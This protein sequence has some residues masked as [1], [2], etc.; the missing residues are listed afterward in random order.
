MRIDYQIL[1]RPLCRCDGYTELTAEELRVFVALIENGGRLDSL[2]LLATSA[3]VSISRC[4]SALTMLDAIGI[5]KEENTSEIGRGNGDTIVKDESNS[6]N[7][8]DTDEHKTFSVTDEF[9]YRLRHGEI[10]SVSSVEVARSIRDS[11]LAEMYSECERL[12]GRTLNTEETKILEGL[13]TQ[14]GLSPEY[15]L[16]YASYLSTKHKVNPQML[17]TSAIKMFERGYDTVE[18]L[19]GYI[20]RAEKENGDV[21]ELKRML[22]INN[23]TLSDAE[24]KYV[25]R[26]YGDFGF[27]SEIISEAYGISAIG[28]SKLSFPYMDKILE[29]WH[30]AGCVSLEDCRK[31]VEREREEAKATAAEK[32]KRAKPK[33]EPKKPRYGSFDV[34]E[35]FRAALN[36]SF[37][38]DGTDVHK[39]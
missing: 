29:K 31:L 2:D 27:S 26:W 11:G 4:R 7:E 34:D 33:A 32:K 5:I 15:I 19:E 3:G 9:E 18:A 25:N 22:G 37:G 28:T 36:R 35:A 24:L 23:R 17:K 16:T 1:F 14:Y 10:E 6:G 38:D 30:E 20:E 12:F 13:H 8:A 21:W 39:T